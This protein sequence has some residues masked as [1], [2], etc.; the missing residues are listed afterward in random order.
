M[1]QPI[2]TV[3]L[4]LSLMLPAS[5]ATT[6]GPT[7]DQETL[8]SIA[9]R[10]K[11]TSDLSVQQTALA[12]LRKNPDAFESDNINA[13]KHNVILRIPTL[14]EIRATPYHQAIR[15][16][17]QHNQ[18]WQ[19]NSNTI[20]K[21]SNPAP[22]VVEREV[23]K[24]T[25]QKPVR[26]LERPIAVTN[27]R[28][29]ETEIKQ[30]KQ[31]VGTLT[32]ELATAR[33]QSRNLRRQLQVAKSKAASTPTVVAVAEPVNKVAQATIKPEPTPSTPAPAASTSVPTATTSTQPTQ[34]EIEIARQ[35]QKLTAQV[36][37]LESVL[38][39]KNNHIRNLQTSLKNASETIKRQH[40]ENKQLVEQLKTGTTIGTTPATPEG[41]QGTSASSPQLE[42]QDVTAPNAE[43]KQPESTSPTSAPLET[44]DE[45]TPLVIAPS[46]GNAGGNVAEA[47]TTPS[48]TSATP[49][50]NAPTMSTLEGGQS[51]VLQGNTTPT[52][53][54]SEDG[55]QVLT[56]N[57][58]TSTPSSTS[59]SAPANVTGTAPTTDTVPSTPTGTE[60]PSS[61]TSTSTP[62]QGVWAEEPATKPA[63]NVGTM[64]PTNDVRNDKPQPLA[65]VT[66]KSS[67]VAHDLNMPAKVETAKPLFGN[68][69]TLPPPSWVSYLV[70][71]GALGLMGFLWWR[72]RRDKKLKEQQLPIPEQE[73]RRQ[74]LRQNAIIPFESKASSKSN[75]E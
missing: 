11:P 18:A 49:D 26:V 48:S 13:L 54:T 73:R 34:Q 7:R 46:T 69:G 62:T 14:A 33:A 59:E 72:S 70:G 25:S 12:I 3:A 15:T 63:N 74:T 35:V 68:N 51:E 1:N 17:Q 27:L 71:T 10:L 36:T 29:Q 39:E 40:A 2:T 30:L 44:V 41:A 28:K 37:T 56:P 65:E 6:Y 23:A 31:Q 53:S 32:Q 47:S 52:T 67:T 61:T 16:T 43:T 50:K 22:V 66:S 55:L 20:G 5:A 24:V 75:N 58:S 64:Q 19:T 60:V 42:L 57:V 8:W 45:N 4:L 9:S 21:T 38:E